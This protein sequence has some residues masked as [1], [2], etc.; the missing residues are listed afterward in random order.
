MSR[1]YC[2]CCPEYIKSTQYNLRGWSGV[3]AWESTAGAVRI[4]VPARRRWRRWQRT[5]Q[6]TT[7][8]AAG[9]EWFW[10]RRL[11]WTLARPK[12]TTLG[13]FVG[14]QKWE[15][16]LRGE[17]RSSFFRVP[18]IY[19][20]S[21]TYSDQP[22]RDEHEKKKKKTHFSTRSWNTSGTFGSIICLKQQ[23]CR[24]RSKIDFWDFHS[25]HH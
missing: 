18:Q 13:L 10:R 3:K 1:C 22:T 6:T 17:M 4:Q 8:T 25:F 12:S 2:N 16:N 23:L 19:D 5:R 15:N 20:R 7:T 11:D 21:L 14:G 24:S 9:G